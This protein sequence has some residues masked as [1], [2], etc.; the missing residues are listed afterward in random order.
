MIR[1]PKQNKELRRN[2]YKYADSDRNGYI[3][4]RYRDG[5]IEQVIVPHV[6][7]TVRK[8]KPFKPTRRQL[9]LYKSL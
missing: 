4:Q 7:D 2:G 6:G 3:Y 5:L 1:F 9:S 8:F